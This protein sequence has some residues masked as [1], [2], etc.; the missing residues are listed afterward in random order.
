MAQIAL[1]P[2]IRGYMTS[3]SCPLLDSL[4]ARLAIT[5]AQKSAWDDYTG[6][7]KSNLKTLQG[8]EEV[9]AFIERKGLLSH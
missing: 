7:L 9:V 2:E 6:A 8:L 4:K 1:P 3:G 5:A